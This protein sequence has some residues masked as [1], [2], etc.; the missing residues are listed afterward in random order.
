MEVLLFALKRAG[1]IRGA[2]MVDLL[3][4]CLTEKYQP[5]AFPAWPV[6]QNFPVTPNMYNEPLGSE[7]QSTGCL[8]RLREVSNYRAQQKISE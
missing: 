6:P 5:L 2:E 4:L 1:A 7:D 8:R 3:S